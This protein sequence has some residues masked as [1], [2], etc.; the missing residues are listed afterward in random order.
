MMSVPLNGGDLLS[1][2]GDSLGYYRTGTASEVQIVS[3]APQVLSDTWVDEYSDE[4]SVI[5]K[6]F[7]QDRLEFVGALDHIREWAKKEQ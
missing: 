4:M 7:R 1:A 3:R 5:F 6:K 2:E